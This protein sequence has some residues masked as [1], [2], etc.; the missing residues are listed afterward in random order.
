MR[1]LTIDLFA[2]RFLN[3]TLDCFS[4]KPDPLSEGADVVQLDRSHQR[5]HKLNALH[6][7]AFI[8]YSERDTD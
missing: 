7:F 8:P 3:Q 6:P 2:S 5:N 1:Q 4:W